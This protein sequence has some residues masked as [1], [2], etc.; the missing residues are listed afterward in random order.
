[1]GDQFCGKLVDF[2]IVHEGYQGA[3][4]EQIKDMCG[5]MV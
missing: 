5:G 4:V 3:F 2:G 1:M